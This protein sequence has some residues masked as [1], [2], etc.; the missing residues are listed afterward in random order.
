MIKRP[1]ELQAFPI[2]AAGMAVLILLLLPGFAAIARNPSPAGEAAAPGDMAGYISGKPFDV[3][4]RWIVLADPYFLEDKIGV[5]HVMGHVEKLA[6]NPLLLA[7]QPWEDSINWPYVIYDD[8]T[9][10]YHMWYCVGNWAAFHAMSG[11][12]SGRS[13][14]DAEK[15]TELALQKHWYSYFISYARSDD[16]IHWVKPKLNEYPYLNFA[17]TNI[18][19]IGYGNASEMHVWLNEDTSDPAR[20]F[21]MDYSDDLW[22]QGKRKRVLML[23]YSPDGMHWK[24]DEKASPLLNFTQSIPDGSWDILHDQ[25]KGQWL[26][27]RRP[28][29]QGA[30]IIATGNQTAWRPN[31][32]FGVS[33]NSRLGPGWSYP[34]LLFVPDEEVERRDIDTLHVIH[35]GTDYIGFLGEADDR[36]SGVEQVNLALSPDGFHWTRF[37]YL[38]PFIPQGAKGAWDAGQTQPCTAVT[39]G[40][41]TYLYFAGANEPQQVQAGYS[42]GIGRARIPQGRWIGLA[43]GMDGGYVLTRELVAAGNRLQIN[44]QG[45]LVPNLG[46]IENQPLGFIRVELLRRSDAAGTL[47]PIPGFTMADSDPLVGDGQDTRVSWKGRTDLSSLKGTPVYIRFHIVNSELWQVRFSDGD[48]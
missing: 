27:F 4:T 24:I 13:E 9:G 28:E 45:I 15:Q 32:R 43:A 46:V 3:G 6:T 1:A 29:Y 31:G 19:W 16:G 12:W 44:F 23:A 14:A 42:T 36:Q 37:P 41:W 18:C 21:L 33:T 35:E 11:R 25:A 20:R 2:F 5:Q 40:E 34:R 26:L 47:K 22:E 8:K 10:S 38:P 39:R 48:N 17:Q 7:D 30:A